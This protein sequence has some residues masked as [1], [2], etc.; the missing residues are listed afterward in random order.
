MRLAGPAWDASESVAMPTP[1]GHALGG[2]AAGCFVV[3]VSAV[4]PRWG[5]WAGAFELRLLGSSPRRGA[6]ALACLGLFADLDLLL[7]MHRGVTH[8]VGAMLVAAVLA[9]AL[10][11]NARP[12]V[13]AAAAAAY[14][15]H[16]VLDWL[17]TDPGAPH[18]VM[19]LWPW[20]TEYYLSAAHLFLRVCREYWLADCWRHN[21]LELGRELV[22][23]TPVTLAAVIAARRALR[24]PGRR[25]ATPD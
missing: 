1:I 8:S 12:Y 24:Q 19:A 5:R 2:V 3:A 25:P 14:G 9:A 17:G 20:S 16:I 22:I 11:R 6:A 21:L 10:A 4:A 23:L 7:G 18:G 15:S 13:A